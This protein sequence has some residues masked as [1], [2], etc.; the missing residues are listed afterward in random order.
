MVD[1]SLYSR[2]LFNY[3]FD[4]THIIRNL[5][6]K[7]IPYLQNIMVLLETFPQK[8]SKPSKN[9]KKKFREGNLNSE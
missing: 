1:K 6:G 9:L 5:F 8:V 7:K 4:L 3:K 2:T